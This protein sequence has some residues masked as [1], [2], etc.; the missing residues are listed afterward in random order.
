MVIVV[1]GEARE[2]PPGTTVAALISLLGF[3]G[4]AVAV[5][6]NREVVPKSAQAATAIPAG[7]AIEVIRAVGG[8]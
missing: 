3:E 6:L 4:T 5:A 7:S 2:V 8:G 1:N